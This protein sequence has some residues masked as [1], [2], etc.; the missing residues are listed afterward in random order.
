MS[1]ASPVPNDSP[2]PVVNLSGYRFVT[3]TDLPLWQH[4]LYHELEAIGVKGTVL[5]ATEGINLALSGS[6][7]QA[8]QVRE[9]L[10]RHV[11][12]RGLWLK[13]S[14]S[15]RLPFAK[16]KVRQR[17]EIISFLPASA[18]AAA[19]ATAAMALAGPDASSPASTPAPAMAPVTL[20]TWLDEGRDFTLLD[21]RN[22]Y[23]VA[24][25]TFA[26]ASHLDIATFREFTAAVEAG[27]AAGTLDTDQPMV[28]F[29]T[30]GIRC[31]KAAPWL[32]DRGFREVHQ[33]DGGI[34]NYFEQCG[35]RHWRGDCFVFDD[36][37]EVDP[38]LIPTGASLCTRC[39]RAVAAGDACDCTPGSTTAIDTV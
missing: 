3:L 31:E 13:Q 21:T 2:E 11:Q 29:C 15:E 4:D 7:E 34:L 6:N 20:A 26:A 23:E 32:L 16:L 28:T 37:V 17:R 36:R 18:I 19:D 12:L 35:G 9:C 10:D 30:G 25:G 8:G 5:L 14:Y 24:S 38:R 22:R 27:L 1:V 33:V 39:Q